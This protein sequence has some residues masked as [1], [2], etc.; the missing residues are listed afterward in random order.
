MVRKCK[1]LRLVSHDVYQHMLVQ[2]TY[3]REKIL[4]C[5]VDGHNIP[6]GTPYHIELEFKLTRLVT[7]HTR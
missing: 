2:V 3:F 4:C 1:S 7:T 5:D 6:K